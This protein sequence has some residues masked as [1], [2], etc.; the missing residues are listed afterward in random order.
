MAVDRRDGEGVAEREREAAREDA[1]LVLKDGE[2]ATLE[3]L[4][5][6]LKRLRQLRD[7]IERQQLEADDWGLL[8]AVIRETMETM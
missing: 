3:Q 6:T 7:R 1:E 5:A 4:E 2:P 8:R